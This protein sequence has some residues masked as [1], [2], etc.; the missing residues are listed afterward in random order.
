[1][2]PTSGV[3]SYMGNVGATQN[4]GF[5]LSL[6][7]V[8]LD[9]LNGWTWEAGV[10]VYS[11]KNKLVSLASGED[12]RKSDWLF[13]GHPLNV[14]YDYKRVGL[15]QTDA[16]AKLYEGTAGKAGMI[17]VLYT[18]TYNTD[19]TPTRLI[20]DADQ[21]VIDCEPNFQG[22]F[23]TRVAYK[24]FDLSVVGTFQSGGILNSTL[25]GANGYLNLESGRGGNIKI[26]YWTENNT[27]A[28]YPDP[29]GPKNSNNPKYGSTSGYFD[30][31]YMKIRTITLGY[32]FNQKWIKA[33]GLTKLR[34]YAT[35]Q[36]PFVF[37]S[38][39]HSES[40]LDPE[41][42]SYANDGANMAV[43]YASNLRRVLTVGYNTPSTH[44]YVVGINVTF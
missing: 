13:K 7:G 1:M 16:E 17:K 26:D 42:N 11:N 34:L 33:V 15:Y 14:I 24:G 12:D 30:A 10:N 35:A 6:N 4:K 9:N 23:N 32:N 18:G 38:P 28:K 40:G 44:N 39:Y 3:G 43:S 27:G 31:S 19:G 22:G 36:N 8:I 37:F 5:E 25:Y 2:P 41:T 21:Q 29:N 20:G